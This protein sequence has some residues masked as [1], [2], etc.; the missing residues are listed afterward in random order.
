MA[1]FIRWQGTIAFI[2]LTALVAA[3]LY[4]FAESLV[5]SAIVNSAESAFGAEV[6]VADVELGYSPL[7][8]SVIDLQVTDKE[9]PSQNLFSFEQATAAIDV[10]QYLFGKV[11]IDQLEVSQLAFG[12]QRA[13]AGKVYQDKVLTAAEQEESL[14]SKAKA[15]LPEV[16]MKLP[17]VKTLLN[18][19]N[20]LTVKASNNLKAS[21]KT[22]Q[23][24]LKALKAKLPNK[25]R[26]KYYQE[27]VKTLS[28]VNVKTLDD[29]ERVAAEY[30]TLKSEFKADQT[31]IKKAKQQVLASK[32]LLVEQS[33]ALKSAPS[34]DWQSIEKKYQLE[35]VDSED[36]AHILFGE[37]ARGYFQKAQWLYEKVA[38]FIGGKGDEV[39]EEQVNIHSEGR[40]VYFD[41][42]NPLPSILIKQALFSMTLAQG[43]FI[44]EGEELTHQHWV[45]GEDSVVNV[46]SNTNGEL[47]FQ[48]HFKIS[49]SGK[50][51]SDGNWSA[52]NRTLAD[53]ALTDTK[54]LTLAIDSA[55]L[56]GQ[57][58]F[59][60]VGE[61]ILSDN[62]LSLN[63][64]TYKGQA[65]S[66][67]TQ[68]LLDT[69]QSLDQLTLDIDVKGK[70]DKPS[71]SIDSSLN[72]AL[73]GAF[74][75]QVAGKVDE[76]KAKVNKGLNEKL[77]SALKLNDNQLTEL[78]DLEALLTDTDK[79][80]DNLKN[81]DVVKQQKQKLKDKLKNKAKDKAKD[82]LKGKLGDLFG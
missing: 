82:K 63:D 21:Y 15:L 59:T 10:W 36:F 44:V 56:N 58:T 33:K 41:E 67:L 66:K 31:L 48:S 65:S 46:F 18:D 9:A 81:S 54:A 28:K 71:L 80:L 7:K 16:D 52:K 55:K 79:S 43:D 53:S 69:I 35:S 14:S 29:V 75:K 72:N 40:F 5:K 26:I 49:K 11:I 73:T 13:K 62:E 8:I 38:P 61:D 78:V 17:D 34:K 51:I 24:K 2:V 47:S 57:G 45:R 39:K 19:S 50:F 37:Q 4:F 68:L 23:E 76:F 42:E 74:K 3:F 60:L 6:N 64:A 12:S 20:L 22:E 27:K 1:R 25:D 70:L 32:K 30:E 77:A